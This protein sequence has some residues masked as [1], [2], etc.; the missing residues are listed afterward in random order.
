MR[1]SF[2]IAEEACSKMHGELETKLLLDVGPATALPMDTIPAATPPDSAIEACCLES[3]LAGSAM[4]NRAS[5][6]SRS[7]RKVDLYL[8][9]S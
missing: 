3:A 6:T 2:K 1:L 7:T 5:S 9:L 8:L 4:R